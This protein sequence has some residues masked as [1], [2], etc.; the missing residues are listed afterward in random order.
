MHAIYYTAQ[1]DNDSM[2]TI[3]PHLGQSP[4]HGYGGER[5]YVP[6]QELATQQLR[7]GKHLQF[8]ALARVPVL[9]HAGVQIRQRF[10]F[11]CSDMT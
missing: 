4:K 5:V 7:Q 9:Q 6:L 3:S 11:L 8:V 2:P 10:A 1:D